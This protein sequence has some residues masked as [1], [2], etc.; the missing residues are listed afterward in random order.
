MKYLRKYWLIALS[1]VMLAVGL[2][3]EWRLV[4]YG[5]SSL[6]RFVW[7]LIAILPVGLPIVKKMIE[8]WKEGSVFNE[9]FLMVAA[10]VAAFVIG[11]YPEGL[12]VIL[13]YTIGEK[14]QDLAVDKAHEE[15]ESLLNVC[16][17]V[18]VVIRDGQPAEVDPSSV[19]VGETVLVKAGARVPLDGILLSSNGSFD[20][21]AITGESAPRIIEKDDVVL[22]G[23]I[24]TSDSVQ[25]KVTKAFEDSTMNRI[26]EMVESANDRKSN[27]E[28]FIRRFA[29]Y[30]T[31]VVVGLVVL[32]NVVP[33]IAHLAGIYDAYSWKEWL[34]KS[35]VFMVISCPCALLVSIPLGYFGGIG[36]ASRHGILVKGGNYLDALYK[37]KAVAFDK[38]G[39]LTEGQF[40]VAKVLSAE[41][42]TEDTLITAL[43]SVEQ[44]SSHPMAKA[45][46]RY[47]LEKGAVLSVSSSATEVAGRGLKADLNGGEVLAGNAK[48]LDENGILVPEATASMPGALI[49][50]AVAG[51]YAGC[52]VLADEP[53]TDAKQM[54]AD[55]HE[56]GINEV[57]VL[58]GDRQQQVDQL[59]N[60]LGIDFAYGDLL[61]QDKVRHVEELHQRMP[62]A[63][64]GDGINDAPVLALADVGIAMG[65][66][67]SDVAVETAN[68]VI[69]DDKP[70][71]V[72]T[73]VKIAKN[74][75]AVVWQ[76]VSLALGIKI[77][78]MV[79]ALFGIANMWMGVF[80]DSGVALLAVLNAIRIQRQNFSGYTPV[81]GEHKHFRSSG[82][83]CC[84]HD[85]DDDDDCEDGCCHHHDDDGC[86]DECSCHHHHE[87]DKGCKDGCCHDDDDDDDCEDGCCCHHD[88]HHHH[89]PS[90]HHH[91]HED[92]QH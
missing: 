92:H 75:R 50:C 38:T 1:F 7:Y 32:V 85:D 57:H 56:V 63:F 13:F 74:T 10:A 35:A 87:H 62:V 82:C 41:G 30:Y 55:L 39:T 49:Y 31:A 43:A 27:T 47:A 9:F 58:S 20:T 51:R 81:E 59:A 86:E 40:K 71:K 34:G 64:V 73:A 42:F 72:A 76:N 28:L 48:L 11:E 25:V 36:A 88:G 67:G 21:S 33:L 16:P 23:M 17:S 19:A 77:L 37:I 78:V 61:P 24:A 83:C 3:D 26:L 54:V 8:E 2:L 91:E 79:L 45:V 90:K 60:E 44:Q 5:W 14:M 70:S 80:A 65:A 12:A 53:K 29:R 6:F 68:V 18:A 15:I 4:N 69:E 66:M 22:S 46:C 89:E 52:V 84:H